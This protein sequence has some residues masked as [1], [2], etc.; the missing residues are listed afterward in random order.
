[1]NYN[2]SDCP[3]IHM[4]QLASH[5]SDF[6]EIWCFNTFQKSVEKI[7]VSLKSEKNNGYFTLKPLFVFYHITL[8]SSYNEKFFRKKN[9]VLETIKT[10]ILC[11]VPFFR[12]SFCYGKMWKNIVEPY[13]PQVTLRRM[14]FACRISK[15]TNTNSEYVTLLSFAWQQWLRDRASVLLCTYIACLLTSYIT[16][17]LTMVCTIPNTIVK[18]VHLNLFPF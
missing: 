1:M 12:K 16:L 15:A 9:K 3:S 2:M 8:S 5:C 6:H 11:S 13:R 14:H 7:Q 10:H 18:S 4:E 17:C